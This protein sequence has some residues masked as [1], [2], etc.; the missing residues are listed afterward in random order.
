MKR[1]APWFLVVAACQPTTVLPPGGTAKAPTPAEPPEATACALR[2][3]TVSRRALSTTVDGGV[4]WLFDA[5]VDEGGE[6]RNMAALLPTNATT[7]ACLQDAP[8]PQPAVTSSPGGT[9]SPLS[10]VTVAGGTWL[11]FGWDVADSSA[12]F[13]V[14]HDGYGV[15][16]RDDVTGTFSAGPP[17]LWTGDRPAFGTTAIAHDGFVYAYG[18]EGFG[19]L[20]E[21]CFVARAPED[22]VANEA[23]YEFYA[24]AVIGRRGSTTP[25]R[26]SRGA[27]ACPSSVT[28]RGRAGCWRTSSHWTR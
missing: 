11:Y 1:L 15:A 10:L 5:V 7:E 16:R 22:Q 24:G 2:N 3:A 23:G 21:Q 13:G 27:P 28:P 4:L 6:Q 19:F 12:P 17:L 8:A 9:A 25:G 20:R 14:R 18:C 26:S